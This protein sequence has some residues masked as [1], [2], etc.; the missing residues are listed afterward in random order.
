MRID[1]H[2]GEEEAAGPSSMLYEAEVIWVLVKTDMDTAS[3]Y[4]LEC[5]GPT[6]NSQAETHKD[7]AAFVKNDGGTICKGILR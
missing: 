5:C 3:A 2:Q 1:N 4:V 6:I 7:V